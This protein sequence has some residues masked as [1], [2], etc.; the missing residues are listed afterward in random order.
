MLLVSSILSNCNSSSAVCHGV[1]K[2]KHYSVTLHTSETCLT[3]HAHQHKRP[4]ALSYHYKVDIAARLSLHPNISSAANGPVKQNESCATRETG[5]L[6]SQV[7]CPALL[8]L[9]V[10]SSTIL[11]YLHLYSSG[12]PTYFYLLH[13]IL[14]LQCVS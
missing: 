10:E 4:L 3:S 6:H 1:K 2:K 9:H 12:R 11:R 5:F 7:L 8:Y 14:Y 13:S